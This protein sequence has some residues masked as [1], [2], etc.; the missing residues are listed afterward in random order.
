MSTKPQ[1]IFGTQNAKTV[2]G[3]KFK[4]KTMIR[5]L[6]PADTSDV[7][8]VC[9]KAGAC[10][11]TCLYTAGRGGMTSVQDARIRKTRDAVLNRMAHLDRAIEEIKAERKKLKRGWK[12]AVR[13]NGTSDLPADARYVASYFLNDKR[14]VFYDYTKIALSLRLDT[15]ID[16]TLSYDPET[17]PEVT[18][19]NALALGCNV[20]VVFDTKKGEP[21]P[22]SWNGY[23]VIDGDEHDLRF[24]DPKGVVVGLRA[25]GQAKKDTSGFVVKGCAQ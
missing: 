5:Y 25:K 21:L 24:L 8:N 3:E 14:V 15:N 16:R 2:K 1:R 6:A 10:K 19:T 18:C 17:V 9:P 12:L 11:A 7:A 13:L 23:R 20:A 4:Y 22:E